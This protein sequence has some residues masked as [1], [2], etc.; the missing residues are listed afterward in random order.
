MNFRSFAIWL[1]VIAVV[2]TLSSQTAA[3]PRPA[4]YFQQDVAYR[5]DVTLNDVDHTLSAMLELDYTNNS[6][7]TLDYIWFHIWPNAY[8]NRETAFAKEQ[9]KE[10]NTRFHFAK[11]E[12]RGYIDSLDFRSGDVALEWEYHPEWIDV[13]RVHLDQPLPPGGR[14]TIETPFF[15]KIPAGFDRLRHIGRHYEISQWYPKPAVYD[16][17][18]WHAFPY[19]RIGEFYGEFGT[20]DVRITLPREYVIMATGDLPEGDPE[21]AF[22]DSLVD[23]TAEYYVL[24]TDEDEPDE[25]AR[26]AWL[27]EIN[28]RE[29]PEPG[30]S[31]TK[32]V[33]FHQ[34]NVHDFAWFTDQRYLVQKGTLWVEDSTRAITM[35]ALY[36]PKYAESWESVIEYI[37]DATEWAGRTY[38]AYPYNHVSAASADVMAGYAM[39]YPNITIISV[40]GNREILEEAIAHEVIHNWHYGIFGYNEREHEWLDEGLSNYSQVPYWHEKY[41]AEN[42]A[43]YLSGLPKWIDPLLNKPVSMRLN[44]YIF[45]DI[46]VGTNDDVPINSDFTQMSLLSYGFTMQ[47]K[48]PVVFDLLHH[49]L[50]ADRHQALWDEFAATWFFAHPGPADIRGAYEAAAGEDLSWFFDDLLGTIKRLDY[51]VTGMQRQGSDVE[52]TV[53]NFGEVLAP[54]EVA[55]LD[56]AGNVLTTRWVAGFSGLQTVTFSG[57]GVSSATTD[58]GQRAPD[59]NRSNDHLPLVSLGPV[60]MHKPALRFLLAVEDPSRTHLTFSPAVW[61]SGYNGLTPGLVFYRGI[62]PPIKNRLTTALLYDTRHSRMVGRAAVT[63]RRYLPGVDRLSAFASY[64]DYHGRNETKAGLELIWRKRTFNNPSLTLLLQTV[65]QSLNPDAFDPHYWDTGQL[66]STSLKL[67][68]R[69]TTLN[70]WQYWLAVRGRLVAG[71]LDGYTESRSA[72]SLEIE[73]YLRHKIGYRK[74]VIARV[75][76]GN[77]VSGAD[78]MAKQHRFWMSGGLDPDFNDF[79]VIQRTG[80]GS[81]AAYDRYYVPEGP[82]LRSP[83]FMTPGPRAWGLNLNLDGVLPGPFNLFVDLAGT[84]PEST[85]IAGTDLLQTYDWET[86]VDA[87]LILS[88]GPID[89]ILPLYDN[90]SEGEDSKLGNRWR[91]SVTF[92][93]LPFP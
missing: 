85:P 65:Q 28:E 78:Q 21:Y 66:N 20:F 8:K 33:H 39:E 50:G 81:L 82:G 74:S 51:G 88:L 38:G 64:T 54:V 3:K 67:K 40:P 46:L 42:G 61:G 18:G 43:R 91:V 29:F 89:V 55:T 71:E 47:N 10:G 49:Y 56:K 84:K 7:D 5:I 70:I 44:K 14:V 68:Y 6:P 80:S 93:S 72:L 23:V 86:Y 35:W 31:P 62:A 27:K 57:E 36:L 1:F 4:D 9:F 90:W 32:T 69:K 63:F 73:G 17:E 34:E 53:T 11:E 16:R 22:L 79:T 19:L 13:A 92:P 83:F 87:G 41:E 45:A 25:K 37:N 48:A 24:K 60:I 77:I 26:K 2:F 59:F 12:D 52:V 15:V 76:V 58:P 30:E 75:W